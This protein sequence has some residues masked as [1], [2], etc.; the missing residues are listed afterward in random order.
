M[1]GVDMAKGSKR[2]PSRL[3]KRR[4]AE[5][6]EAKEAREKEDGEEEVEEEADE[7]AEAESDA[8][9]DDGDGEGGK[10]KK[11]APKKKP[12]KKPAA[13]KKPATKRSRAAKEVR[14]KAVWIVY[15]NASKKIDTFPF[16][17]KA[18]AEALLAKKI[19]EKKGTFYINLVKEPIEE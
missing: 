7:E 18:E 17:Q 16:N 4:E 14:R 11:K 2:G 8:D 1:G 13:P 15:D 3:D 12:A 9:S 19:E 10:K 6:A 5:A